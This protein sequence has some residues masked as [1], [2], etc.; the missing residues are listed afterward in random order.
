VLLCA[1]AHASDASVPDWIPSLSVGVES[2]NLESDTRYTHSLGA[3]APEV[4]SPGR[5]GSE[6][7]A[8]LLSLGA[9]LL[10]PAL[11]DSLGQ[12]RLFLRGAVKTLPRDDENELLK[13]GEPGTLVGIPPPTVPGQP[14]DP[15]TIDRIEGQG[16]EVV[17]HLDSPVW[18]ASLGLAFSVPVPNTADS[19]LRIRPS[20]EYDYQEIEIAQRF[21]AATDLG[22]GPPAPQCL[23]NQDPPNL[24]LFSCHTANASTKE[25]EHW[26]GPGLE[27]E[28]VFTQSRPVQVSMF[29]GARFL[30]LL[31]DD[32]YSVTD[33]LGLLSTTVE[34]DDF[35]IRGGAGFRFSWLGFAH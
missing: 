13:F 30:F 24:I 33:S 34:R 31:G 23:D 10:G 20:L 8:T 4:P 3:D 2:G 11:T 5:D 14:P 22:L 26:L 35:L 15:V 28:L 32:T 1:V 6:L 25:D 18:S 27:L 21:A 29:A 7:T 16:I 9:E 12:P 19:L 17:E